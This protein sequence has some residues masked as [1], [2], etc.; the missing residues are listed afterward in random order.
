VARNQIILKFVLLSAMAHTLALASWSTPAP[1]KARI[2]ATLSVGFVALEPA[3]TKSSA[4][5]PAAA[6]KL[7]SAQPVVTVP[8]APPQAAN[9]KSAPV[10]TP[11]RAHTQE[12]ENQR[13][14]TPT[15][16]ATPLRSAR[17]SEV[18]VAGASQTQRG[19]E[20]DRSSVEAGTP[21]VARPW[22]P[23][24]GSVRYYPVDEQ[25]NTANAAAAPL[26][27]QPEQPTIPAAGIPSAA[28]M[29]ETAR[30]MIRGRLETDLSRYFSYPAIA[31]QHGWQGHVGVA[32]TVQ[33]DGQLTDAH[34]TRSS[35]YHV[36]D[37]SAL[38]ALRRVGRL[39]QARE[40]LHGQAL[41]M[42]LPVIYRLEN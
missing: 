6:V 10:V 39:P 13:R 27:R 33:A 25:M 9:T 40:W 34:I 36:L 3:A 31:R 21:V 24:W 12:R 42:E 18:V 19:S 28:S 5:P 11:Q 14:T 41:T 2:S 30:A 17:R 15:V 20:I 1:P 7:K 16:A 23:V 22:E 26:R 29:N 8:N 37:A 38:E 35:G 4:S 32:F